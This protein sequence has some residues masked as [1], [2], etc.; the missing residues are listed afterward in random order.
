M[1]SVVVF[2]DQ[3]P[4]G[5]SDLIAGCNAPLPVLFLSLPPPPTSEGSTSGVHSFDCHSRWESIKCS[6]CVGE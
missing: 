3:L 1:E 5:L 4:E 6:R 2:D